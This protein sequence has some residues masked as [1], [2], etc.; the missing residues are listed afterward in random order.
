M[1][2]MVKRIFSVAL[3]L[4]LVGCDSVDIKGLIVP[5][6]DS[7]NR[8]CEQSLAM[9]GDGAYATFTAESE[10][11]DIYVAA[12]THVADTAKNL[13]QFVDI[14]RADG[15][16]P[17]GYMVGDCIDKRGQMELYVSALQQRDGQQYS[18]PILSAL[19]NHDLFFDGWDS[20]RELVGPSVYWFEAVHPSGRDLFITL[21]SASGTL[22]RV[23]TAWLKRLLREQR[24]SYCHCVIFSHVNLFYTDNSQTGSGNM[25]LE[26]SAALMQL[27]SQARVSLVVQGHDHYRE[28][29]EF[30]GV[31]YVIIG[32]MRDDALSPEYGHITLTEQ[33]VDVEW[34]EF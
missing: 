2:Q 24:D 22:G 30:M 8:R 31:R 16:A 10:Q 14:V 1:L 19:G 6:S 5:V 25:P 4:L 9:C 12:D 7:V 34:R 27:F 17:F 15:T 29:V 23:Q 18:Q 32:T 26:E 33:G 28:D 21:D 20:F 13:Q 3:A 11:Y